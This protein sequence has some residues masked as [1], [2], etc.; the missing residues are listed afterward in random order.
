MNKKKLIYQVLNTTNI[1]L[2]NFLAM[3]LLNEYPE[4]KQYILNYWIHNGICDNKNIDNVVINKN[5][6]LYNGCD[7]PESMFFYTYKTNLE[8][9]GYLNYILRQEEYE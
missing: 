9:E 4:Y 5:K 3:K 8:E 6:Y 2:Y 1:E 7:N